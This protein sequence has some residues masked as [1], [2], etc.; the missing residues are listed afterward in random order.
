MKVEGS[1]WCGK[2]SFEGEVDPGMVGI[3]HCTDCQTLSGTAFRAGI[4]TPAEKF[5]L[6][7]TPKTFIKTAASGRTRVHAFC[8]DCGTPIYSAASENTPNYSLRVGTLKQRAQLRPVRQI[9]CQSALP[10]SMNIEAVPK[11]DRQ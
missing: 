6:R 9:W 3:C 8:S 5:V 7:G 4:A 2:I 11:L 10:W 1:C